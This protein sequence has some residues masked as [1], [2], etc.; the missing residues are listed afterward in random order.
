MRCRGKRAGGGV[1]VRHIGGKAEIALDV[2][3][4]AAEPRVR[5]GRQRGDDVER[6]A[7]NQAR[8]LLAAFVEAE[9]DQL[10]GRA[11]R[12]AGLLRGRKPATEEIHQRLG[13]ERVVVRRPVADLHR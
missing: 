4:E 13:V 8:H 7:V 11:P 6:G 5:R 1:A 3:E 9:A 10:L 2:G 12:R